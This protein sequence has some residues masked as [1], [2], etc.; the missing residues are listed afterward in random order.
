M[1][2][3][4]YIRYY[5]NT[6]GNFSEDMRFYDDIC[7][8]AAENN[9]EVKDYLYSRLGYNHSYDCTASSTAYIRTLASQRE[10]NR[11]YSAFNV[12]ER[13]ELN[14][15][16]ETL[17]AKPDYLLKISKQNATLDKIAK[18]IANYMRTVTDLKSDT[19]VSLAQQIQM[20]TYLKNDEQ[21]EQYVKS[22]AFRE[23]IK[24][25]MPK[26]SIRKG[27]EP[28]VTAGIC[29]VPDRLTAKEKNYINMTVRQHLIHPLYLNKMEENFV[30]TKG[31][32][33]DEL[34]ETDT[35]AYLKLLD[36]A[37]AQEITVKE[38]LNNVGLKIINLDK[39]LDEHGILFYLDSA[40]TVKVYTKNSKKP[41]DNIVL[42]FFEF[43]TL[44]EKDYIRLINWDT[45]VP[46]INIGETIPV[47][48][49]LQNMSVNNRMY[50]E[51]IHAKQLNQMNVFGG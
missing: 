7:R 13:D 44:Y 45:G 37:N 10:Y 12:E 49:L 4:K 28:Y 36:I 47:K 21:I 40:S 20:I 3:D 18:A 46:C 11:L 30:Y 34:F 8:R 29:F 9:M 5:Y 14:S 27:I 24:A 42:E 15:I 25:A 23:F 48:N 33:I 17:G 31:L 32:N 6:H 39:Q 38:V 16:L 35:N 19:G 22:N 1:I 26:F 51:N 41:S 50:A 43:K 2:I